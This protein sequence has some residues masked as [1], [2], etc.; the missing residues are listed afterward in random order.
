MASPGSGEQG[1]AKGWQRVS[2]GAGEEGRC[3]ASKGVENVPSWAMCM[4]ASQGAW[5]GRRGLAKGGRD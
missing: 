1:L 2:V 4:G 5:P 3:L